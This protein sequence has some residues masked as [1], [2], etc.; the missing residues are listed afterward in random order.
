MQFITC[1][2]EQH[3]AAILDI[4]NEAII[5]STALYDYEPRRQESMTTWFKTK[6]DG[7]FPVIGAISQDRRLLGFASYGPFRT[8]PAYKY[9]VEHSVYVHKDYRGKG[10]GRLLMQRLIDA[11]GEQ[12]YHVMIG[13]IDAANESSIFLHKKLGFTHVGTIKHAG[14]KFGRWLDLTL[15]QLVLETPINPIDG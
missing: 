4:M 5:N 15:Y 8:W 11:A 13:A 2:Y 9:T 12:Q 14:F 3:A 6:A 10:I 1:T 7:R